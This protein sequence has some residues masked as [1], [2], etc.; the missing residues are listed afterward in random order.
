MNPP[1][2]LLDTYPK[3]KFLLGLGAVQHTDSDGQ[4]GMMSQV[5]R[6]LEDGVDGIDAH[7]ARQQQ[8]TV[9]LGVVTGSVYEV[10]TNTKCHLTAH[11]ALQGERSFHMR[12]VLFFL[13]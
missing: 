10:T 8:E 11:T 9:R 7:P 4:V 12:S 3:D 6:V 5:G 13:P 1:R 2:S